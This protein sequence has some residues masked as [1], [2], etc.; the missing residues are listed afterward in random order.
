MSARS[1]SA[2]LHA[3]DARA[4][5]WQA[6]PALPLALIAALYLVQI[7]PLWY[8]TPDS[9]LYLSIARGLANGDGLRAFGN[10]QI[11][12]PPGYPLLAAPAFAIS[13]L[14]FLPLSLLSVALAALLALCTHRW[15]RDVSGGETT[16]LCAV[17]MAN[18]SLGEMYRR[19]LSDFAFSAALMLSALV[20]NRLLRQR[21]WPAPRHTLAAGL[22]VM[23][24]ALIRESG[25]ALVPGFA[26]AALCTAWRRGVPRRHAALS[27]AAVAAPATLAVAV[28][29]LRE[30]LL[31]AADHGPTAT[32]WH[33]FAATDLDI[34]AQLGEGLRLRVA[35]IGR[36][37][38][39][40][41]FKAYGPALVWLDINTLVYSALFCLLAVGWW[42]LV[43]ARDDV[44]AHSFPFYFA[45]YVAWPFDAGT[46]Y[47]LPMLPLIF[48]S[49][50]LLLSA[51]H[52]LRRA[53]LA[54]LL[55]AHAA[56]SLGYW[57][58]RDLPRAWRCNA[59][60][61]ALASLADGVGPRATLGA[62]AATRDCAGLV[63]SFLTD[64][65][66]EERS[67]TDRIV[68]LSA[69]TTPRGYRRVHDTAGFALWARDDLASIIP[70]NPAS[71]AR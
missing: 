62:T 63:L 53:L 31:A 18:V 49:G 23:Y 11:H 20:L 65:R 14:P 38:I 43:R 30:V 24:T 19:A 9:A 35:E 37:A 42:R 10:P 16:L 22:L 32:H 60:W 52:H 58:G 27:I 51:R 68:A 33:S 46:R 7:S 66:L 71:A 4:R 36:L 6:R 54:V 15:S 44:L 2:L 45:L 59:D 12:L 5:A 25:L 55:V 29:T 47:L 13:A 61:P 1:P 39:P 64:R 57:V 56:V 21:P 3:L 48:L 41:M 50:W 69:E 70:G 34:A 8:P 17:V 67:D 28:F 26:V 40:G